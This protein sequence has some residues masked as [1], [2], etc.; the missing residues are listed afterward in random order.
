MSEKRTESGII[1][2]D[3]REAGRRW[4]EL[5]FRAYFAEARE[6]AES[7]ARR[8]IEQGLHEVKSRQNFSYQISDPE[9]QIQE[10]VRNPQAYVDETHRL[11]L[12]RQTAFKNEILG[13]P[14]S[15]KKNQWGKRAVTVFKKAFSSRK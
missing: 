2:I 11:K 9:Q 1:K 15:E 14:S 10:I 13:K 12:E 3:P 8:E 7:E 4:D 6:T 5:G